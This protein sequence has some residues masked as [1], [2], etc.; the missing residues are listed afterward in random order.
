MFR[1]MADRR[2]RI[3]LQ[4]YSV[5]GGI[6]LFKYGPF[7][8]F[9][10]PEWCAIVFGVMTLLSLAQLRESY[11]GKY[12]AELLWQSVVLRPLTRSHSPTSVLG[13][14]HMSVEC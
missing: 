14:I 3:I 11:V 6:V 12:M 5:I 7:L 9:V 13:S 4:L 2:R 1:L 8:F 10:Y